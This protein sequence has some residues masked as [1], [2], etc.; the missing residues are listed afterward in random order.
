MADQYEMDW[1]KS[2]RSHSNGACVE[3]ARQ[4][5]ALAPRQPADMRT[6]SQLR[7]S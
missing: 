1:R 7:Q 2:S 4:M 5:A 3:V 6:P